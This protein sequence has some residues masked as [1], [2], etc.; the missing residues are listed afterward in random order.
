MYVQGTCKVQKEIETK[1]N[2]SK[3]NETKQNQKSKWNETSETKR[4][5]FKQY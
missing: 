5:G 1:Q 4:N 2:R 3:Q